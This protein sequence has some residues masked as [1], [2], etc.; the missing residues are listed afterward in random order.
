MIKIQ[1]LENQL[2]TSLRGDKKRKWGDETALN[3]E[4]RNF[5]KS[6]SIIPGHYCRSSDNPITH[7]SLISS[8]YSYETNTIAIPHLGIHSHG[9]GTTAAHPHPVPRRE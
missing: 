4:N 6:Y 9:S 5:R 1:C 3:R 2:I 7:I 8:A